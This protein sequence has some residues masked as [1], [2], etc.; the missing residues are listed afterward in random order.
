MIK[1]K[2]RIKYIIRL[3]KAKEMVTIYQLIDSQHLLEGKTAL[4]TGGSGGISVLLLQKP[5]CNQAVRLSSLEPVRRSSLFI[6]KNYLGAKRT[7]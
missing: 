5:S 1:K 7:L 6:V 2:K 4:I 3:L